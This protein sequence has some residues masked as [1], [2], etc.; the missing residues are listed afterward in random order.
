M[1][2]SNNNALKVALAYFQAWNNK[3]F[4]KVS[5]LISDAAS[6]EMPINYY[7]HKNTF[8]EA[9]EFTANAASEVNLL[10]EFGDDKEAILLYDLNLKPIG[11]LR[12]AEHF[13]VDDDKIVHIRHI[14]DTHQLRLAGFEKE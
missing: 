14:H 7:H 4:E 12:I 1:E 3:D 10:A 8:V 11:K 2:K 6:F 13:K 9:V 5:D